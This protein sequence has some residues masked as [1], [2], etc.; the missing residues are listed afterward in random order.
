MQILHEYNT[1]N[2][3]C[4]KAGLNRPEIWAAKKAFP[5]RECLK[6]LENKPRLLS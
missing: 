6:K 5:W 4:L 3:T 2:G 1:K